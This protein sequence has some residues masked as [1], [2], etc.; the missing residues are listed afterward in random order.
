MVIGFERYPVSETDRF[1]GLCLLITGGNKPVA[2]LQ[3][4]ENFHVA[5]VILTLFD[6]SFFHNGLIFSRFL[7]HVNKIS[8]FT[9]L[10]D[11][12]RN[13]NGAGLLVIYD[14]HYRNLVGTV[15]SGRK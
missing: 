13:N 10:Y 2:F 15:F 4:T 3:A 12:H 9:C 8:T 5:G 1:P 14:F 6:I 7:R 11:I